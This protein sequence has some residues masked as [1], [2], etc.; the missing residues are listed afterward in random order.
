[1]R[2]VYYMYIIFALISNLCETWVFLDEHP[3][4]ARRIVP[5][6][7]SGLIRDTME[8]WLV[9]SW[10]LWTDVCFMD[11]TILLHP[12]TH[13]GYSKKFAGY[14]NKIRYGDNLRPKT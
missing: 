10:L 6:G 9:V 14:K 4:K 2:I 8:Q 12:W 11:L 3:R 7:F 5:A 1:M 13:Y